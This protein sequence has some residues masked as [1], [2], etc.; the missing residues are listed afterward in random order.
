[1]TL[2]SVIPWAALLHILVGMWMHTHLDTPDIGQTVG[3]GDEYSTLLGGGAAASSGENST[4][5]ASILAAGAG[6]TNIL[7]IAANASAAAAAATSATYPPIY[8]A[9]G[10]PKTS[11]RPTLR[12][13]EPSPRV[14]ISIHPEG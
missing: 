8:D 1:M 3:A 10:L 9:G 13:D 6:I 12:S 14:C 4:S 11:T 7:E 2:S 5:L